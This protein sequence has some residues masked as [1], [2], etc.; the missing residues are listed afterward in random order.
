[1]PNLI[2]RQLLFGNPDVSQI[3]IS[4]DGKWIS[5]IA[6]SEGVLNVW[7]APAGSLAEAKVMTRDKKRGIRNHGWTCDSQNLLYVQDEGGDENWHLYI[8]PVEGGEV[9]DLTPFPQTTAQI[10]GMSWDEPG[11]M[12]VGL[13]NRDERFHDAHLLDIKSGALTEVF[14]NEKG[15][16]GFVADYDLK[17]RLT[18]QF[19]PAGSATY[20]LI[21]PEGEHK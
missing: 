1:M 13:N 18:G 10:L 4:P 9:R 6:P 21:T 19:N 5:Y 3:N 2:P 15:Y 14:R 8:L 11:K 17:V 20:F 12:L 16:V 7:L